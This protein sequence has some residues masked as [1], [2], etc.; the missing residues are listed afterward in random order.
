MATV[1]TDITT[2][3]AEL[4]DGAFAAFCD[5]IE[6]M[7]GVD[8][9]CDRRG[10][11]TTT[12]GSL[13][14]D[15]KGFPPPCD[16]FT[17]PKK[18]T[19]VH[20]VKAR[21]ALNGTFHLAFDQ[22]GL[23]ILSGVIVMLP[24]SRILD[25]VKRGSLE[26][27][28]NLEDAA[29]EVGNLLVG[30]WD[31]I[32]REDCPGHEHLLKTGTFL[33][34]PWDTPDQIELEAD[35]ELTV[36]LYEMTMESY[37]SFTCAALFPSG[38]FTQTAAPDSTPT[39]NE[40]P[41]SP[42]AREQD[43]PEETDSSHAIEPAPEI[44]V[45]SEE[46]ETA[47]SAESAKAVSQPNP[48]EGSNPPSQPAEK[49]PDRDKELPR[50]TPV[51]AGID[52]RKLP[53]ELAAAQSVL[54]FLDTDY[55]QSS[56]S[57]GLAEFLNTPASRIMEKNVIW[58]GPEETVQDVL[59]RMQQHNAGYV[60]VGANGVLEGLVSGSNILG[61]VSLYLRPTFAKWRR[62]QD[63]ATLGVK[64]KWI[65]S[66][67]VRTVRPDTTVATLIESMCRCGGRCLPVV[68]AKGAVQGIVTVFDI[69]LR[70][71]ASDTSV[72]FRGRP[73]QAPPLLS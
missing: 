17:N 62:P 33:G 52:M 58:A 11:R 14:E 19:A 46:P 6:G 15:L 44:P 26:D 22:G 8:V 20:L 37:P 42:E 56:P 73:R 4:S 68:D 5:D 41:Q 7:F 51:D 40:L 53:S 39:A 16:T 38:I 1:A 35:T 59:A 48:V 32:F 3:I 66:R 47:V 25:E 61:A 10:M 43:E 23:F 65:M 30:S 71:L 45:P 55:V 54:S 36:V 24:E 27:A 21:G 67:P 72:S 12:V 69:L 28:M 34:K 18:L 29:R 13:R 49:T 60:L 50:S 9:R 57:A 2:R 31:R 64:V 63:D 70:I